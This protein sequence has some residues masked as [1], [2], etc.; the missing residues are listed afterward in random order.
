M[1]L[2]RYS[3]RLIKTGFLA[4]GA[5]MPADLVLT[6][7]SWSA[8]D[9]GGPK[10][11]TVQASGSAESLAFLCG[12]LGDRLEIYN[13]F[14]DPVWWG[15]L[16]DLEVTLGSIVVSLSLDQVYNRVAVIRPVINA[17]GSET[18]ETT[19]WLEDA[20]SIAHYGTRELLYGL[21]SSYPADSAAT[22]RAQLLARFATPGPIISTQSGSQFSARLTGQGTWYKA[23]SIYFSN[24]DGLVEHMGESGT[25]V[26]GRHIISTG[27]SFGE[28]TPDAQSNEI[29]ISSGDFLPL[30]VG[31]TFTISGASEAANNDTYVIVD[32]NATNEINVSVSLTDEAAGAT[33]KVSWGDG[34]SM[35]NIAQ[36]FETDTAWTLTRVAVKVRRMGAP[37]D[38]FRIGI[39]ADSGGVPGSLL[40]F[41]ETLGSALFTELTWTEFAFATPVALSAG[42][43][44]YVQIRRTGAANLSDGYEIAVDEDLGYSDGVMKLYNGAAW[45]TRS[46]DADMPFR[47][48]GEISSTAQ[49]AKALAAVDGFSNIIV[50]VDSLIPVRQFIDEDSPVIAMGVIEESLDAGTSTNERLIARAMFDNSVVV[51]KP[52]LS[53]DENLVL[54]QDGKVRYGNGSLYP[55]GRLVYGEWVDI[56]SVL[57]L[58][59]LGIV[60][61]NSGASVYVQGSSYDAANDA[62]S[63]EG[64]AALDPFAALA[65]RQG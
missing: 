54:G 6:P 35:D 33:V 10:Q 62:L 4:T 12:W 47:V 24:Q 51:G 38:S 57:L 8:S 42:T 14:G 64:E 61:A 32:M 23:A 20:N 53:G 26:I 45:V 55:P 56:D 22:V 21:P 31:D 65:I 36:A 9:R 15:V 1:T 48:I 29:A 11:C 25:Q 41:N 17:D 49:L 18:S 50:Q 43:T 39:Y 28:E 44:Y 5:T 34:I 7:Q 58:D 63:I 46:P 59:G 40:A 3:A 37:S 16:W 2:D 13:E 30:A 19:A 60:R 52:E 27:I